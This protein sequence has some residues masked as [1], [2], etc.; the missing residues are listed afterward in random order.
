MC[1][2][3]C[4]LTVSSGSVTVNGDSSVQLLAEEAVP[5]DQLDVSVSTVSAALH[6]LTNLG[7][8]IMNL[9]AVQPY[10]VTRTCPLNFVPHFYEMQ[11]VCFFIIIIVA[12]IYQIG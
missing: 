4:L 1:V 6:S 3:V 5:L 9:K 10:Y 7:Q 2:R 11:F 12:L 8:H